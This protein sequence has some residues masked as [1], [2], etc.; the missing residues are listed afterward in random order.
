MGLTFSI[1]SDDPGAFECTLTDE[2]KVVARTFG[3]TAADFHRVAHNSRA[4]RFQPKLRHP[5]ARALAR[6]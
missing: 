4:A 5:N 2:L 1:N 3:F 6:G